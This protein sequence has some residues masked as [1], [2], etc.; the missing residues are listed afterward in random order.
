MPSGRNHPVIKRLKGRLCAHRGLHS[1]EKGLPENSLGAFAEAVRLGYGMELDVRMSADGNLFVIHDNNTARVT[2]ENLDIDKST[3]EQIK[4]LRLEGTQYAIPE[5]SEV[6][7][8][9]GGRV[10]LIIELKTEKNNC[11]A[12]GEAVFEQLEGYKGDYVIESFD[13]RMVRWTKNNHPDVARGQL[14][15]YSRRHGNKKIPVAVDFAAQ[16]LL[17]NCLTRPDFIAI[18]YPDRGGNM[19]KMCRK[20]G[21][22]EIDWTLRSQEELDTCRRD[23]VLAFIFENFIPDEKTAL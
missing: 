14:I 1:K 9:V 6:L 21:V 12:L 15:I 23:K 11:K 4:A 8:L 5:F 18:H 3:G 13:P 22:E 2:G 7:S 19:L 10:P 20:M 17:S 16:N